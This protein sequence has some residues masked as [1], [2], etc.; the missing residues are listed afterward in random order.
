MI[1]R[2]W[3]KDYD[4]AIRESA[5]FFLFLRADDI[6]DNLLIPEADQILEAMGSEETEEAAS[7]ERNSASASQDIGSHHIEVDWTAKKMATQVKI[8]ELLQ[9]H[10]DCLLAANKCARFVIIISAWD[11]SQGYRSP[12]EFV[13]RRLPFL[14]Q[15]LRSNSDAVEFKIFGISGQGGC[16]DTEKERQ[17]L[18]KCLSPLSRIIAVN[19]DNNKCEIIDP[20]KWLL[21]W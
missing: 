4:A 11:R 8:V 12:V 3:S 6:V 16:I 21:Q 17:A 10:I 7:G 13:T 14:D 15:F 9:F 19:D 18:L 20:V 5:G 1:E 2:Q